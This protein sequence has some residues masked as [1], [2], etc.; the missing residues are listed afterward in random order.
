MHRTR[1][2]I[3]SAAWGAINLAAGAALLRGRTRTAGENVAA[4]AGGALMAF[5][6]A[7]YFGG[8]GLGLGLDLDLDK[9]D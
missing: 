3:N 1:S 2:P 7:T 8:L 5:G 9:R 4:V 6:L